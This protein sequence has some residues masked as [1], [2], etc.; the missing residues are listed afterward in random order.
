MHLSFFDAKNR[1]SFTI[2]LT[3]IA[4]NVK[5][6]LAAVLNFTTGSHAHQNINHH[7]TKIDLIHEVEL[8]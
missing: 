8:S 2:N 4:K 1:N 7:P 6:H 3:E 5:D